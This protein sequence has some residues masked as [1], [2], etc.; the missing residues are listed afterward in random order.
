MERRLFGENGAGQPGTSQ[1]SPNPLYIGAMTVPPDQTPSLS[2]DET[3]R[4]RLRFRCWHRGIKETDLLLGRFADARIFE[5]D[6][7]RLDE[8]EALMEA[9]DW[10]IYAWV[11]R[12][13]PPPPEFDTKLMQMLQDFTRDTVA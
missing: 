2:A 3:R 9:Q 12:G 1:P 11:S 7:E 6:P 10:D 4:K 5:L 8:L 13:T